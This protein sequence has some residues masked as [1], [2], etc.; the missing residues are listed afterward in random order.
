MTPLSEHHASGID[1]NLLLSML[2]ATTQQQ[3][4]LR[5]GIAEMRRVADEFKACTEVA[6]RV[7]AAI[8]EITQ[9]TAQP[10]IERDLPAAFI[11]VRQLQLTTLTLVLARSLVTAPDARRTSAS[12]PFVSTIM[13]PSIQ[14][15]ESGGHTSTSVGMGACS[16]RCTAMML[17]H[18]L[19]SRWLEPDLRIRSRGLV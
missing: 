15:G 5:K 4:E 2:A 17:V 9:E 6:Q 1:P 7:N 3:V 12:R 8:P 18:N 19:M 11:E 13:R 14:Q 10:G 16:P